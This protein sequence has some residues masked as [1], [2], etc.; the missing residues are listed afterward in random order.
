MT[1]LTIRRVIAATRERLFAA[2]TTPELLQQWW[3]PAGVRCIAAEIDLRPGGAYRIGNALPDGQLI[4]ISGEF[5]V[6]EPPRRLTYSWR[7]GDEPPSRV[8]IRFTALDAS[9]TEVVVHHERIHTRTVRDEHEHGWLGCLDG[10]ER[11]ALPR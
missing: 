6:V 4:W 9:S 3:G 11:W 5:E 10:L 1:E 2:W 7:T 8:T